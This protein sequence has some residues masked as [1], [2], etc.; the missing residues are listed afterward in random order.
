MHLRHRRGFRVLR[1]PAPSNARGV[2]CD[3]LVLESFRKLGSAPSAP[4]RLLTPYPPLG[5]DNE[6]VVLQH[7]LAQLDNLPHLQ[8]GTH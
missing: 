4:H 1:H 7:A 2:D 6:I 5:F 8:Q 3:D